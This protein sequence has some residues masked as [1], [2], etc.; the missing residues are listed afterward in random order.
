MPGKIITK[1]RKKE[2]KKK[3]QEET[4]PVTIMEKPFE[5]TTVAYYNEVIEFVSFLEDYQRKVNI[6]S[7]FTEVF[8]DD[9]NKPNPR[10]ELKIKGSVYKSKLNQQVINNIGVKPTKKDKSSDNNVK[11]RK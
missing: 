1:K 3:N 8:N 4:Q 10:V 2:G 6:D 7:V 11:S 5:I 9:K